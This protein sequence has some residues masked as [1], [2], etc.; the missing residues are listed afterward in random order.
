M[1]TPALSRPHRL[2][3][4]QNIRLAGAREPAD[5][6]PA[7][8]LGNRL[9]TLEVAGAGNGE[10]GL[11]HVHAEIRQLLGHPQ[12][13]VD[14]HRKSRRLLA[15]TQRRIEHDHTARIDSAEVWVHNGHKKAPLI[16]PKGS[17]SRDP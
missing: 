8:A 7:Y 17:S 13:L 15:V 14:I 6:R 2:R 4:A 16:S 11:Q 9:H 12:L 10:S 5:H 3:G 1:N